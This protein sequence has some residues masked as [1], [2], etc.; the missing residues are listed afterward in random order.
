MLFLLL[1]IITRYQGK[2]VHLQKMVF[3]FIGSSCHFL[4]LFK[5]TISH[6]FLKPKKF[7]IIFIFQVDMIKIRSIKSFEFLEPDSTYY[8]AT[9]P[10]LEFLKFN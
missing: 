8:T 7:L 9:R 1:T 6:F 10:K 2:W 3:P 5:F 4:L